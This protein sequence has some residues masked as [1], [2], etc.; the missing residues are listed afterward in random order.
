MPVKLRPDDSSAWFKNRLTT[1]VVFLNLLVYCLVVVSLF[2]SRTKYEKQAA[3][4]TQNLARVLDYQI[5][6]EIDH[7]DMALIAVKHE[8]EARMERGEVGKEALDRY[9]M[10]VHSHLP[11]VQG[12]RVTNSRGDVINGTG[13]LAPGVAFNMSD[14][15]YFSFERDHPNSD[16]FISKPVLGRIAKNRWTINVARRLNN[17]DGTFAGVVYGA[18]TL[19]HLTGIFS[20]IDLGHQ[21]SVTLRDEQLSLIARYPEPKGIGSA[22]GNKI[23]AQEYSDLVKAGNTYATFKAKAGIDGTQRPFSY[24]RGEC[25]V[26]A[27]R[28]RAAGGFPAGHHRAQT[29]RGGEC[30]AGNPTSAGSEDGIRGAPGA[31]FQA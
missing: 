17:P 1:V 4:T 3:V 29:G 14:R 23:V 13:G 25:P 16:L 27:R 31:G 11:G 18:F 7:I 22:I 21:G 10:L 6:G 12:L 5:K 28:K 26:P 19:D 20:R 24:R 30:P 9:I 8:A 15:D 2:Q